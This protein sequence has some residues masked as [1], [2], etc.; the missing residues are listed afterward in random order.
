MADHELTGVKWGS[1]AGGDSGGQVTWSFATTS[2]A[3]FGFDAAISDPAFQSLIRAAFA[4]WEAVLDIDFV[5]VADSGASNIRL[6][7][8][9]IDGA[10]NMVGQ[11]A[12]T[13]YD[14]ASGFDTYAAGEI[15]FDTA[16]AWSTD[17]NATA[18]NFYAVALHEIGHAIGIEHSH[19]PNTIMY[20]E[21]GGATDLTASDIAAGRAVYG[22][23]R[24]GDGR[25]TG[26]VGTAGNDVL[27]GT[28]GDDQLFGHAGNDNITGH[29]G[30]D[31]IVAGDG[32]DSVWAGQGDLGNDLI[33]GNAGNDVLGGGSGNDT[34]IGGSGSDTLFGGAGDDWLELGDRGSRTSD[35]SNV[36]NTAW[37]GIGSD[38][39]DGDNTS[40]LLGGGSGN[41]TI[42]GFGANDT[43]FGGTGSDYLDGGDG[44]DQ[45][46][47]GSDN[48][49]LSGGAGNDILWGGAG[50]DQIS[51]GAGRDLFGV[52][53]GV[54]GI[55]DFQLGTDMLDLSAAATDFHSATEV[56]AASRDTSQGLQI[57]L[58]G[59]ASV[60][61][62]G[63]SIDDI[64]SIDFVF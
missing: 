40:D 52:G 47:G 3:M 35:G 41:D 22:D 51:G 61:L 27:V 19:D 34:L 29:A 44:D 9:A 6:G 57:D 62:A 7:W 25:T 16:E 33:Y 31:F 26:V 12:Y 37:A 64:A 56:S 5:E 23:A 60:V 36:G 17:R 32:N 43:I 55:S 42:S 46:Y 10:Y 24:S 49:A 1:G 59:G 11:Q 8:D 18:M 20:F 13:Y 30:D 58:G 50:N 53:S 2:G 39:I 54:D 14:N 48:D 38:R 63:L 15:R 4:A 45:L 28:A 21:T